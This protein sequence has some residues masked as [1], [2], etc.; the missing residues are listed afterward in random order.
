MSSALQEK[1]FRYFLGNKLNCNYFSLGF[2]HFI[3]SALFCKYCKIS[4]RWQKMKFK[5]LFYSWKSPNV[6]CFYINVSF[7]IILLVFVVFIS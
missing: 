7:L 4:F 3:S 2:V 5:K 6:C 1:I